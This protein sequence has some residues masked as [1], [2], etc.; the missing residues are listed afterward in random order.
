MNWKRKTDAQILQELGIRLKE[1]RQQKRYTQ[2]D[3]AQKA[4]IST[5]TLQKIEYGQ[6]PTMASFI[7]VLR[8]LDEMDHLEQFLPPVQISPMDMLLNE[9]KT[10]YRIRKPKKS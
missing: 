6:N 7:Q 1:K 2:G 10:V 8:A 9:E 4:G 3:L 5:N